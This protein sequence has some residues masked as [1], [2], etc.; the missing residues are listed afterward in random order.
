[1]LDLITDKDV[2]NITKI[3][4]KAREVLELYC[5]NKMTP[6]ETQIHRKK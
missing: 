2:T 4:G 6:A 5:S 1:M 3:K